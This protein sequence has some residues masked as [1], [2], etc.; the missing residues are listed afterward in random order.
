[1]SPADQ[2]E[3]FYDRRFEGSFPSRILPFL[4]LGNLNHAMNASML[5][6]LGIT[7]VVSV[8]ESALTPPPET[9]ARGTAATTKGSSAKEGKTLHPNSLFHEEQSGRIKVLDLKDVSDD[10]I[11]P[12]RPQ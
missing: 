5:H 11:D 10:G 3:W 9:E 12:L 8:G 4:Y 6:A 2:F 1:M 7:H